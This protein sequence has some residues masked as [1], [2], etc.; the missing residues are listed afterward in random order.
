ML[1]L[2]QMHTLPLTWNKVWSSTYEIASGYWE[3]FKE[4]KDCK[5]LGTEQQQCTSTAD[6]LTKQPVFQLIFGYNQYI[7]QL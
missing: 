6:P 1:I 2:A 5:I 3:I 4:H 7:S